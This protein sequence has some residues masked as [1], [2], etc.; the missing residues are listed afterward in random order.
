[1]EYDLKARAEVSLWSRMADDLAARAVNKCLSNGMVDFPEFAIPH[2]IYAVKIAIMKAVEKGESDPVEQADF[3]DLVGDMEEMRTQREALAREVQQLAEGAMAAHYA[4]IF[5]RYRAGKKATTEGVKKSKELLFEYLTEAERKEAK[6]H[7]TITVRNLLGD[8]KVFVRKHG[9]IQQFVEGK[10]VADYCVVFA[11]YNIPHYD[12]VLMK[13]LLLRS[14]PE[15][16]MKV[17]NKFAPKEFAYAACPL[18][19]ED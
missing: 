8:F 10:H 12:E 4:D 19:A 9:F 13:V 16:L 14:D 15:R 11:D 2:A 7:G 1:L 3:A 5:M 18:G 17:A 6:K